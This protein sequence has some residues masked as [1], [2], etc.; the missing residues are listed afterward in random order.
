V[1]A[2][3]RAVPTAVDAVL[4]PVLAGPPRTARVVAAT[5]AAAYVDL[6]ADHG[7]AGRLVAILTPAAT[8]VPAGVLPAVDALPLVAS[9]RPGDEVRLGSGALVAGGVRLVP[10][11]WWDS[12]VPRLPCP[13]Q[14]VTP[15]DPHL[16]ALPDAVGPA[17]RAL[18]QALAGRAS[19]RGVRSAVS[20][21]VGLGPGLTPAGDDVLAGAL[22]ALSAA[23]DLPRRTALAGAVRPLLGRTSTLSASYLRHA[24][25][26]RAMPELARFLAAVA[27]GR[28]VGA[29]VE[30]LLR[31]GA[32]SGVALASGAVLGLRAAAGRHRPTSVEV[33]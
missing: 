18:A 32:S 20:R 5:R 26:G 33:A 30:D 3:L 28:A 22:V 23:G 27:G 29:V 9:L 25:E 12:R 10:A 4:H 16:P 24:A 15:P 6:G 19:E 17:A 21:L 2:E 7:S 1:P 13:A 14:A 8:R 11:R 31:V